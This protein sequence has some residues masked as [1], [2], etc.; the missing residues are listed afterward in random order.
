[1]SD[2]CGP[3]HKPHQRHSCQKQS[4][5]PP[6]TLHPYPH[7]CPQHPATRP[8]PPWSCDTKSSPMSKGLP[9][10]SPFAG[11]WGQQCSHHHPYQCCAGVR[12]V[13]TWEPTAVLASLHAPHGAAPHFRAVRVAPAPTWDLPSAPRILLKGFSPLQHL[14]RNPAPGPRTTPKPGVT[15]EGQ[16]DSRRGNTAF[17]IWLR[18][19]AQNLTQQHGGQE[20][21]TL[22]TGPTPPSGQFCRALLEHVSPAGY[23][24]QDGEGEEQGGPDWGNWERKMPKI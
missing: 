5:L 14:G 24:S 4:C 11:A 16:G 1:M 21:G 17:W 7:P 8:A 20:V 3:S 18:V 22:R 19:L 9:K 23:D 10:M 15:G 6:S 13:G 12:G 2:K